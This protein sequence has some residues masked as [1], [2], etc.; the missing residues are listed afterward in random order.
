MLDGSIAL[1]HVGPAVQSA[2]AVIEYLRGHLEAR[3]ASPRGDL[4][5]AM[6]VAQESDEHLTDDEVLATALLVMGAGHETTT[7]LIGNGVLALL[8]HPGELARLARE[9]GLA[10]SAVEEFLRF[11]SPV[12][13]TSRV[14]AEPLELHGRRVPAREEV[15][16]LLGGANRD[17]AVFA[18]PERL[19]LARAD[20][21]HVSFGFG[22][23][24]CLGAGLARLEG[25]LAIGS[26]VARNPR[27]GLAID[28]GALAWRPGWLLRGLVALPIRS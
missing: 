20:N 19:D 11:D 7:N 15:G 9:P 21:R 18:D 3:R 1:Q 16:V 12:Q 14:F 23:H 8:R 2:S 22:I 24:F 4:L 13:A 5:S 17:P 25:Q 10:P 26:L 27:L 6:L 28:E